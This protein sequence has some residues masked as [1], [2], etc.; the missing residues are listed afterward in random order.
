MKK[1]KKTI[2]FGIVLTA[3]VLSGILLYFFNPWDKNRTEYFLVYI[4]KVRDD[5]NDFWSTL[6]DGAEM[7][8]EEY[9][10]TLEILAP[11]SESDYE[12]QNQYIEEAIAMD[13]DAILITPS[14]LTENTET[15]KKVKEHGIRLVFWDAVVWEEI[16]VGT[17][18]H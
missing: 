1:K 14:S 4:P 7:A 12:Q 10:V 9:G 16:L 15:L 11:D 2:L 13:P 17:V 18:A 3:V 5:E 6:L 8:A